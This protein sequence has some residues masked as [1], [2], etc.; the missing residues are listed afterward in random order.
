VKLN[1]GA[2]P[3]Q[4]PGFESWDVKQGRRAYP[5]DVP[6][7]AVEEIY[8]SHVLEHISH[9]LTVLVLRDWFRALQPGGRLRVAVPDFEYAVKKFVEKDQ[10]VPIEAWIMG[11]QVD[12]HDFHRAAFTE[13]KLRNALQAA[14]FVQVARWQPEIQDCAALPVSLNL[15]A[16][17]PGVKPAR[18]GDRSPTEKAPVPIGPKI[19]A[20]WSTPRLGFMDTFDSIYRCLPPLGVT[21]V[22]GMGVFWGQGMERL[23]E[24]A[25]T[26]HQAE[27]ILCLD[28]DS[29][30]EPPDIAEMIRLFQSHP[31]ADALMPLQYNRAANK[32]LFT[33]SGREENGLNPV[34]PEELQAVEVFPVDTGHFG[35]TLLRSSALLD[36]PHPW[37]LAQPNAAGRWEEGRVDEDI[38]FWRLLKAQ[39]KRAFLAP[40][41]VIGHCEL[42]VRW[43]SQ[44]LGLTWQH[45]YQYR[46]SGK[47]ADCFGGS[48]APQ[49]KEIGNA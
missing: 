47:P 49:K 16:F 24:I 26:K 4:L 45:I 39:G 1:I 46:D 38:Y 40:H 41:V 34:R 28:Y 25:I 9:R 17:K 48:P 2:G 14:G 32:L 6:D 29:V 10:A 30:F 35:L 21:L 27:I 31:E 8:A 23:F 33:V 5:L 13:Q 42:S 12:E 43:P 15:Q 19:V 22:R 7:G 37:F 36:L 20:I 11:G 44:S 3:T 18:E